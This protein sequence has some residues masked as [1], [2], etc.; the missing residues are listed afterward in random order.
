MSEYIHV[1]RHYLSPD[2]MVC[3][4]PVA[5]MRR[6]RAGHEPDAR[7]Q[8][9]QRR[10]PQFAGVSPMN[11]RSASRFAAVSPFGA[12]PYAFSIAS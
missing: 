5:H 7:F 8:E 1:A 11:S 12:T 6:Y 9:R 4:P 10:A 2:A 3:C